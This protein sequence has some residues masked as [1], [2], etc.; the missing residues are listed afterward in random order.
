MATLYDLAYLLMPFI[1]WLVAGSCKFLINS[2]R[3]G[4]LAISQIGYG[5]MPSNHSA[6]V[7]SVA[8][9]IA[10]REGLNSGA[11]GVAVGLAY[12]VMMDANGLRIKVGLQARAINRLNYNGAAGELLRERMGHSKWEIAAGFVVGIATAFLFENTLLCLLAL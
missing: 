6:I 10:L 8:T 3:A 11:F 2:I 7:C 5:G 4:E 9:L 1:A 12:I